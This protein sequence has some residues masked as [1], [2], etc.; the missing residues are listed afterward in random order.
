MALQPGSYDGFDGYANAA[1]VMSRAG[2][3]VQWANSNASTL[4][5]TITLVPGLSGGPNQG[6]A[7]SIHTSVVGGPGTFWSAWRGIFADRNQEAFVSFRFLS[8]VTPGSGVG[9]PNGMWLSVYDTIANVVQVV[10]HINEGNY[11]FQVYEGGNPNTTL[12]ALLYTTNNNVWPGDSACYIEIHIKIG[13]GS[14]GEVEFHVNN[15]NVGSSGGIT[16]QQSANAW[17]DAIDFQSSPI[18]G[19]GS[20]TY[21]DDFRYNDT[22]SG[23]GPNP[24][25][26]WMGDMRVLT[27]FPVGND[28]VQF[29]PSLTS[30]PTGSSSTAGSLSN[31]ANHITFMPFTVVHAGI[32]GTSVSAV[33]HAAVTGHV[34]L[35]IYDSDGANDGPGTLLVQSTALTNPGSGAVTFTLGSAPNLLSNHQYYWA[36]SSDVAAALDNDNTTNGTAYVIAENYNATMPA[37]VSGIAMTLVAT[38]VPSVSGTM[39]LSNYGDASEVAQDGDLTYNADSNVGDEDL[40]NFATLP[41]LIDLIAAVQIT[42][43]ARQDIAGTRAF[44]SSILLSGTHVYSSPFNLSTTYSYYSALFVLSP[45]TT[46]PWTTSEVNGMSA[47]YKV[48]T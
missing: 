11:G 35:G 9:S 29:T 36:L 15:V 24:Y 41:A 1:Q 25:N 4:T 28:S 14:S 19:F 18:S 45:H 27:G 22:T 12:G 32:L 5:P 40:L 16:T 48:S 42:T 20:T 13:T 38:G 44:E 7:L 33:M 43:C 37:T 23:P 17:F 39:T 21:M 8:T 47:G 46:L 26:S 2:S 30:E 3:F 31:A 10:I 34:V 6:Q